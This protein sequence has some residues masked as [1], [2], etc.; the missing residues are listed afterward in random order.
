M[1]VKKPVGE[2]ATFTAVVTNAEGV[3]LPG[4]VVTFTDDSATDH[5]VV[6]PA[7][8]QVATVKGTVIE[9]VTVTATVQGATGPISATDSADFVDNTPAAVTLVAS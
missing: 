8:P 3:A 7:S 4:A 2:I 9:V 5:P 6:D 1:P